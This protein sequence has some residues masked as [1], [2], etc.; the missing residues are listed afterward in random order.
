MDSPG[1]RWEAKAGFRT[2]SRLVILFMLTNMSDACLFFN[3][4]FGPP[5]PDSLPTPKNTPPSHLEVI[6]CFLTMAGR[7]GLCARMAHLV[8]PSLAPEP[9]LSPSMPPPYPHRAPSLPAE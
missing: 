4:P 2:S 8:D 9:H 7:R 1:R 3:P 5:R 6:D